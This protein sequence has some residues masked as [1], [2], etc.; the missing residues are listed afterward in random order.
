MTNKIEFS[1]EAQI[2]IMR[3]VSEQGKDYYFRI[4]SA[5]LKK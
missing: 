2:Q 5:M 1:K 4:Y 3:I